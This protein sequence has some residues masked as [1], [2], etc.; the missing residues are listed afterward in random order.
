YGLV[1]ELQQE[2]AFSLLSLGITHAIA[3]PVYNPSTPQRKMLLWVGYEFE[4]TITEVTSLARLSE[5]ASEKMSAEE[6]IK[7]LNNEVLETKERSA[8]R[9]KLFSHLAHDIRTPINNIRSLIELL[10]MSTE[11]EEE[12]TIYKSAQSN[13]DGLAELFQDML[14]YLQEQS[15]CLRAE[16]KRFDLNKLIEDTVAGLQLKAK[17]NNLNLYTRLEADIELT[18][19]KGHIRRIL[20]NLISNSLKYTKHGECCVSASLSLQGDL[21]LSVKDTGLGMTREQVDSVFQPF[22]RHHRTQADGLGLG[23]AVFHMLVTKNNGTITVDS[24]VGKGT[25]VRI[26]IPSKYI[27]K[28]VK[29]IGHKHAKVLLV[30]DDK[31]LVDSCAKILSQGTLQ[32]LTASTVEEALAIIEKEEIDVLMTDS[33]MPNGGGERLVRV[34]RKKDAKATVFV[35]SGSDDPTIRAIFQTLNITRFITKPADFSDL[36]SWIESGQEREDGS[37]EEAA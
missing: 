25:E 10:L 24:E 7:E 17:S 37:F 20:T 35:I 19:D 9:E 18:A 31:D 23:M 6:R 30:D 32:V 15:S 22:V 8:Q 4:P 34:F 36:R 3:F 5:K 27:R 16:P 29:R 26:V 12:Q 13:C 33:N 28:D 1:R 11:D 21:Y 14:Y 2:G